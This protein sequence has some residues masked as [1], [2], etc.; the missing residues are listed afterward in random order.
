MMMY[1]S[2]MHAGTDSPSVHVC[3]VSQAC[4]KHSLAKPHRDAYPPYPPPVCTPHTRDLSVIMHGLEG[5]CLHG[6]IL[7]PGTP[8]RPAPMEVVPAAAVPPVVPVPMPVFIPVPIMLVLVFPMLMPPEPTVMRLRPVLSRPCTLGT[9]K[10]RTPLVRLACT[11][12]RSQLG[13]MRR[14][15]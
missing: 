15:R 14:A 4:L 1:D 10:Y 6:Y 8:V 7:L 11:L 5:P 12:F 13:G 3:L 2:C 9:V